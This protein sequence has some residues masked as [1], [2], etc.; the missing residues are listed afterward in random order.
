MTVQWIYPIWIGI[1]FNLVMVC[2]NCSVSYRSAFG[3]WYFEKSGALKI[4][5]M[6]WGIFIL[7]ALALFIRLNR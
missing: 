6:A 3:H 4:M 5:A 1:V 2:V 7:W